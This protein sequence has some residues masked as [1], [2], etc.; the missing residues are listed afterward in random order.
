M[1]YYGW[2]SG[3]PV[4]V[5]LGVC[6]S[7]SM[8][9]SYIPDTDHWQTRNKCNFLSWSSQYSK[10]AVLL[11]FGKNNNFSAGLSRNSSAVSK[12]RLFSF[13]LFGC[14]RR[15]L[16]WNTVNWLVWLSILMPY[17]MHLMC[18]W[19]KSLFWKNTCMSKEI[20]SHPRKQWS[21]EK[22]YEVLNF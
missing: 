12:V 3:C 11:F 15:I 5:F 2:L 22:L 19:G 6:V 17:L 21:V 9:K 16:H 20:V 10:F 14:S 1:C 4:K 7:G 18:L 8:R 13:G